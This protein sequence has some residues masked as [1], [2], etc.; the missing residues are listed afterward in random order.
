MVPHLTNIKRRYGCRH[1]YVG[2]GA[3]HQR[4][5]ALDHSNPNTGDKAP[6]PGLASR[7][8]Y[9][10]LRAEPADSPRV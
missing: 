4:H 3:L 6:I 1:G 10:Y 8:A 5:G 9:K 7:L 2:M